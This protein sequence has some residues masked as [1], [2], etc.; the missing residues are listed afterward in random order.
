MATYGDGDDDDEAAASTAT[1]PSP[2]R[3]LHWSPTLP[4]TGRPEA[5]AT[6]ARASGL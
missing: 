4:T 2:L 6:A 3:S 1:I 5:A